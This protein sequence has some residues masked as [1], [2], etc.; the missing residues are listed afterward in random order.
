MRADICEVNI[1]HT[2]QKLAKDCR[3]DRKFYQEIRIKIKELFK[4]YKGKNKSL[5][6]HLIVLITEL[7]IWENIKNR[8]LKFVSKIDSSKHCRRR[9]INKITRKQK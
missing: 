4:D 9:K 2:L 7:S 3:S 8:L 1:D 5:K 6:N